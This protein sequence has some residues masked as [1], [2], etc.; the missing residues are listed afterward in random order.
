MPRRIRFFAAIITVFTLFAILLPLVSLP[1]RAADA[2]RRNARVNVARNE[3]AFMKSSYDF[4][5][6]WIWNPADN[7]EVTVL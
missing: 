1:T 7:G 3:E 5:A 4:S 6:N 2:P